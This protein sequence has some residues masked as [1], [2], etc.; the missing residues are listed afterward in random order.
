MGDVT[1]TCRNCNSLFHFTEGEQVFYEE[2]GYKPPQFCPDCRDIRRASSTI[3]T[4]PPRSTNRP[5]FDAICS[6]CGSPTQVP[7][8]PKQGRPV[9]CEDCFALH[10][11]GI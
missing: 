2:R 4:L 5:L 1:L 10:R 9:Y 11:T 6:E 8:Q 7:F 3:S